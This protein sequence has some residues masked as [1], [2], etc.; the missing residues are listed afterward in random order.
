MV[1]TVHRG[2]VTESK[3]VRTVHMNI[4]YRIYP[5]KMDPKVEFL[6]KTKNGGVQ[7]LGILIVWVQKKPVGWFRGRKQLLNIFWIVPELSQ[8]GFH[9]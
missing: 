2:A 4:S 1:R 6:P 3:M 7:H 9:I 5:Q 8:A